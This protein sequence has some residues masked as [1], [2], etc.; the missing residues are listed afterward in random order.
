MADKEIILPDDPRAASI[1]TVTGWVS[2]RGM[3][4][5][6]DERTARYDGSTH[7]KCDTCGGLIEQR[8]YC[9][10]C[11]DRREVEKF[12][13]MPRKEWDGKAMLYSVTS[14]SYYTDLDEALCDVDEGETLEGLRLVICEPNYTRT[15]DIDY[16]CD[17]LPEEGDLPEEVQAAVDAFNEAVSGV[18]LSWHPGKFALQI[19]EQPAGQ[20]GGE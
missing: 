18:I 10:P 9:R 11:A 13:A 2:R 1:Q 3:F 16:F 20:E 17:D 12:D 4:W 8:G 14:D 5:G 19:D 15:L 6:K 7:R